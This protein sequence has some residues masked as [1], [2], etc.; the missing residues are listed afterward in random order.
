MVRNFRIVNGRPP[1][2]A[3]SCLKMTS[4]GDVAFTASAMTTMTG[5]SATRR[6]AATATSAARLSRSWARSQELLAM[7]PRLARCARELVVC[8]ARC[9]RVAR[10][11]SPEPLPQDPMRLRHDGGQAALVRV[12]E[13]HEPPLEGVLEGGLLRWEDDA[14][15][16]GPVDEAG[17]LVLHEHGADLG[18]R[19][20]VAAGHR[21]EAVGERE[22]VAPLVGLV[23]VAPVEAL[24]EVRAREHLADERLAAPRLVPE[25][26]APAP[27]RVRQQHEPALELDLLE[28]RGQ[29]PLRDRVAE[30]EADD[31]RPVVGGE[32][33]A[34]DDLDLR[35]ADASAPSMVSWSVTQS[36]SSP[37]ESALSRTAS[38]VV[39]ES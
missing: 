23:G 28:E 36:T 20:G 13:L 22:P 7:G 25:D 4:P 10:D 2:P 1:R 3:R 32:L 34:D 19:V 29:A 5:R 18:R 37:E 30:V 38:G 31:V 9:E 33:A 6:I 16:R 8:A 12:E 26:A 17:A 15:G 14:P 11:V 39:R 27:E 21:G 35:A 24:D